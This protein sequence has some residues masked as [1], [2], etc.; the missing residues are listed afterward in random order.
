MA[1][2]RQQRR[3]GSG[4]GGGVLRL[5]AVLLLLSLCLARADAVAAPSAPLAGA[6]PASESEHGVATALENALAQEEVARGHSTASTAAAEEDEGDGAV[7]L[8]RAA[9]ESTEDYGFP[10]ANSRHVP[11]P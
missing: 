11:H 8:E 10:S 5:V 9:M 3:R 1:Q 4:G 6:A 2:Q 7:E